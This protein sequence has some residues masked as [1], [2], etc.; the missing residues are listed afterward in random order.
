[1]A[2]VFRVLHDGSTK[3]LCLSLGGTG[4]GD[5][6]PLAGVLAEINFGAK[7]LAGTGGFGS[8]RMGRGRMCLSRRGENDRIDRRL[9]EGGRGN[10][11]GRGLGGSDAVMPLS[12][13]AKQVTTLEWSCSTYT[14]GS[15]ADTMR[16]H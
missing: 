11:R 15:V 6:S 4:G 12:I 2:R 3:L 9:D 5:K 8:G 7:S 16:F 13:S 1:M 10:G 14:R